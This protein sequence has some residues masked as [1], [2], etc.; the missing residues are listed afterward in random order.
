MAFLFLEN[1]TNIG[2]SGSLSLYTINSDGTELDKITKVENRIGG[3]IAVLEWSPD[4]SQF[5]FSWSGYQ[6]SNGRY[7]TSIG[8]IYVVNVDG[9]N[10]QE[11]SSGTFA[12]WSPN[13]S[14][15]AVVQPDQNGP[16]EV[17][18]TMDPNGADTRVLV[19]RDGEG[20]YKPGNPG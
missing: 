17:L 10:L 13:G 9:T 19:T 4:D 12:S 18:I 11:I 6:G 8:S 14:R 2:N 5:L 15:I 7:H 20:R 1:P 16:P 3:S